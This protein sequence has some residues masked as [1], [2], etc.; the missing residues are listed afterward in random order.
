MHEYIVSLAFQDTGERIGTIYKLVNN[1]DLDS[2]RLPA[3]LIANSCRYFGVGLSELF[4][5]RVIEVDED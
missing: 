4:E 5:V 3:S 2:A 1:Q